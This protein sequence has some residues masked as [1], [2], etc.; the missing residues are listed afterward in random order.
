MFTKKITD[1][2]GDSMH[3]P[4]Q[5]DTDS[6]SLD[7]I[8]DDAKPSPAPD[9]QVVAG[10][11]EDFDDYDSFIQ[12]EVLLPQQG[13]HMQAARVLRRSKDNKGNLIGSFHENPILN[14]RVYDVLFPDGSCEQYAA[15]QIAENIYSQVDDEGK[16]YLMIAEIIDHRTNIEALS[17]DQGFVT[18]NNG[19]KTRIKTTKGWELLVQWKDGTESWHPLKDLKAT[20]PIEL[21]EYAIRNELDDQPAFAWWTPYTLKKRDRIIASIQSRL[22]QRN[23]KYGVLVPNSVMEA[24]ELDKIN[25][26]TYWKDAIAKEMTNVSVAFQFL[27]DDDPIPRGYKRMGTHLIF[28]VKMDFTRKARLVADGHKTAKPAHCTYAG[29]VLRESVR[30]ALTFAALMDLEVLTADI[31][32]A[33]LQAPPSEQFYIIAGPEWGSRQG[34]R[35]LVVRALYGATQ[36]FSETRKLLET[37][38]FYDTR[39]CVKI[40][41]RKYK[42]DS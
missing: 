6:S 8:C 5:S 18:S 21:A 4:D 31:Q 7:M 26:N 29:V 37:G 2:L 30:I 12:T 39:I 42:E 25:G 17:S 1:K 38:V 35:M 22:Q 15:N 34:Q 33:Y 16:R 32:N 10:H 9:D 3:V 20:N 28:D 11:P 14:T 36:F 19:N 23:R 40:Y 24:Y 13:E 27:A 41:S